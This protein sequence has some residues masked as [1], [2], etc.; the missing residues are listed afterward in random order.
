MI[1]VHDTRTD[2]QDR[3]PGEVSRTGICTRIPEQGNQDKET[4][5]GNQNMEPGQVT[6][7]CNQAS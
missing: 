2:N 4:R 3:V 7:A 1:P 5:T 6:R